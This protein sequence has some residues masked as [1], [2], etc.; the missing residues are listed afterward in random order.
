MLSIDAYGNP[1][2]TVKDG[3]T[4]KKKLQPY[5]ADKTVKDGLNITKERLQ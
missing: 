5:A 2:Y 3:G 4:L 1:S